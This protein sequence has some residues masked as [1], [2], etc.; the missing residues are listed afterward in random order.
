[1]R[2]SSTNLKYRLIKSLLSLDLFPALITLIIIGIAAY[3]IIVL[4]LQFTGIKAGYVYKKEYSPAHCST[5]YVDSKPH[6]T[7][8]AETFTLYVENMVNDERVTNWHETTPKNYYEAKIGQWYD[9]VCDCL[10]DTP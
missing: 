2:Y 10:Q 4:F 3:V 5:T 7:C 8:Y 9:S 1:M 6:V